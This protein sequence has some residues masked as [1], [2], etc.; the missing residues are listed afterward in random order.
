MKEKEAL[1][2]V[3]RM[4]GLRLTRTRR[5]FV[6]LFTRNKKPISVLDILDEFRRTRQ[7]VNKTTVYREIERWQTLHIV[8]EVLFGERV[9]RYELVLRGHHHHLV[10]VEC[11][12]VEEVEV[13]ERDLHCQE[14]KM[15][16]EKKFTFLR[17]SLEFFGLC[18]QCRAEKCF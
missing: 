4:N 13:N 3:L 10:C 12:H 15:S 5:V 18:A 16:Q 6:E 17:H 7:K 9:S 14:K 8:S 2:Q 11:E 1:Y